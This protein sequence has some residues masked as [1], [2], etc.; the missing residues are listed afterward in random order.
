MASCRY[1][2]HS[3]ERSAPEEP[4]HTAIGCTTTA[5]SKTVRSAQATSANNMHG[6]GRFRHAALERLET[7]RIFLKNGRFAALRRSAGAKSPARAESFHAITARLVNLFGWPELRNAAITVRPYL[8]SEVANKPQMC[9][10]GG[11]ERGPSNPSEPPDFGH[12]QVRLARVFGSD[13]PECLFP[14]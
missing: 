3:R 8:K 12:F 1:S 4:R 13:F 5:G 9:T 14:K 7:W 2:A 10:V 11:I 6:G